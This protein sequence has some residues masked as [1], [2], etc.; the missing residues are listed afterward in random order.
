[1]GCS[2]D[3]AQLTV[4][5]NDPLLHHGERAARRRVSRGQRSAVASGVFSRFNTPMQREGGGVGPAFLRKP[6]PFTAPSVASAVARLKLPRCREQ[7][8]GSMLGR[9][10]PDATSC[11]LHVGDDKSHAWLAAREVTATFR[12]RAAHCARALSPANLFLTPPGRSA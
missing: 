6:R 2:S 10:H 9:E 11:L 8:G 7:G 5:G 4:G 1:M 12:C 3:P